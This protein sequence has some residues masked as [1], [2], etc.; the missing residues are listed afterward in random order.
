MGYGGD[1]FGLMLMAASQLLL[2]DW[3]YQ[4]I[5]PQRTRPDECP[6]SVWRENYSGTQGETAGSTRVARSLTHLHTRH[7]SPSHPPHTSHTLPPSR[8]IHGKHEASAQKNLDPK[9][10]K[11][12]RPKPDPTRIFGVGESGMGKGMGSILP[13]WLNSPRRVSGVRL[14]S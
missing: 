8:G 14:V 10:G 4:C 5:K 9:P 11:K 3:K 13:K 2:S 12:R 6:G 1:R 7:P